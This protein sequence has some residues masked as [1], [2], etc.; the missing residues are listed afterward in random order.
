MIKKK[1]QSIAPSR[2]N[3]SSLLAKSRLV[4]VKAVNANRFSL[5]VSFLHTAEND[6]SKN[7]ARKLLP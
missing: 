5:V 2:L 4:F 6:V 3:P 1:C 7:K